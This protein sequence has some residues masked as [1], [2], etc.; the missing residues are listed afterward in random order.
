MRK[1]KLVDNPVNTDKALENLCNYIVKPKKE[2]GSIYVN[3]RGISTQ[4]PSDEILAVQRCYKK[5][6]ERKAYHF[7]L[8]TD[9]YSVIAPCE[10]I[11]LAYEVSNLFYPQFQVIYGVHSKGNLHIHFAINSVSYIDGEE[12]ILEGSSLKAIR[13]KAYA[14]MDQYLY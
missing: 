4:N 1:F 8:G 13:E 7:V 12:L 9:E 14:I 5:S 10:A 11:D 6:L 3:S 2:S